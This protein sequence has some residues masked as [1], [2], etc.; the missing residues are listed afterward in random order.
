MENVLNINIIGNGFDKMHGVDSTYFDFLNYLRE[1]KL[2]ETNYICRE[3]IEKKSND[4]WIDCESYLNDLFNGFNKF[5]LSLLDVEK[6]E[7][8]NI[9][10]N[11]A[12]EKYGTLKE[13]KSDYDE[14]IIV[15]NLGQVLNISS[16]ENNQFKLVSNEILKVIGSSETFLVD[17]IENELLNEYYQLRAELINYLK[18]KEVDF[19][20]NQKFDKFIKNNG[21]NENG[22]CLNFN[23]TLTA[24]NYFE[25]INHIHGELNKD[26][27]VWGYYNCAMENVCKNWQVLCL[28]AGNEFFEKLKMLLDQNVI[29]CINLNIFGHSIGENDIK[30][31]KDILEAIE[32]ALNISYGN[33]Y[34]L[35]EFL[36]AINYTYYDEEKQLGKDQISKVKNIKTLGEAAE[37]V[38]AQR[39]LNG[40]NTKYKFSE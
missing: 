38:I 22:I 19:K 32:N 31:Y 25:N 20:Y 1:S 12:N 15:C 13:S 2:A 29:D 33:P 6:T 16:H 23:Y 24:Q 35:D 9:F 39:N 11:Y 37:L 21:F 14:F 10:V 34:I 30:I 8:V 3:M 36:F 5:K 40:Y 26:N 4:T 18:Q 28:N 17:K 7:D 27:I